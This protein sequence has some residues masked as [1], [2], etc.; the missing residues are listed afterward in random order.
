MKMGKGIYVLVG[1]LCLAVGF[2]SA[3]IIE[4][5]KPKPVNVFEKT[6][7]ETQGLE[8]KKM[9]D[10]MQVIFPLTVE[11]DLFFAG[12]RV[13]LED[14]EVK[15]RLDRE[16][17]VNAYWQ[18]NTI[19][20][21]K[22][23]NRYFDEIEKILIEEGVPTDFKYLAL[24]ESGFRDVVSP[25]GAAGF[26]QFM[27]ATGKQFGLEIN[28]EID[29]RYNLDKATHAACKYLKD[30][31]NQLGSWTLAAASYNYGVNGMFNRLSDQHSQD[32]YELFL[33]SETSRYVFRIL[34]MKIIFANPDRAGFYIEP[35]ELYQP[36]QYKIVTVDTT[37][38]DVAD[39]A[40]Q[41]DLKYKHIK[42]LNSWL[43]TA[44]LPNR[45]RKVYEIK[46]LQ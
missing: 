46:I 36:F 10:S 15:E 13:P 41:F 22:L 12:E 16:L 32:Y 39:F 21:M 35:K 3:R 8:V 31:K 18:S 5:F 11:G 38:S 42:T 1:V 27:P 19:L 45:S 23:A 37:V 4:S 30:A 24:I 7:L 34:A 6:A 20:S 40:K 9:R 26:W 25:S 14:N 2:V 17:Q 44:T 28:S 33:T 29:E 43:R